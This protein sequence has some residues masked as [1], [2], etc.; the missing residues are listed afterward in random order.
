MD[1]ESPLVLGSRLTDKKMLEYCTFCRFV[2]V[3]ALRATQLSD[4]VYINLKKNLSIGLF[5][6]FG[7]CIT[8]ET[9]DPT[10]NHV[11]V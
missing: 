10:G 11:E 8:R 7:R 2:K 9:H 3:R 4:I 6:F 1:L 5:G